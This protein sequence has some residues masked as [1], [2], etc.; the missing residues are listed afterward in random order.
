MMLNTR[1]NLRPI[2]IDDL[3]LVK[4]WEMEPHIK[5]WWKKEWSVKTDPDLQAG[6]GILSSKKSSIIEVIGQKIGFIHAYSLSGMQPNSINS[7]DVGIR[8]F[9]GKKEFLNQNFGS[10]AVYAMVESLFEDQ[11]IDRIIAEPQADNWS[12]IIALQRARFRGRGRIN[13][14]GFNLVQLTCVRDFLIKKK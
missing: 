14:P 7:C 9:I 11:E 2:E 12:A 10:A 3:R 6:E 4:K 1:I 5:R 8:F 13:R